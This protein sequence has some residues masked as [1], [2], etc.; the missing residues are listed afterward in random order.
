MMDYGWL[1]QQGSLLEDKAKE[2][3]NQ[4]SAASME[5]ERAR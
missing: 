2:F 1:K 4:E 5:E 3:W